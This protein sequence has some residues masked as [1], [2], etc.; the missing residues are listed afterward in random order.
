MSPELVNHFAYCNIPQ[1]NGVIPTAGGQKGPSGGKLHVRHTIVM[2]NKLLSCCLNR[3]KK[4]VK[5]LL[6]C[7]P[8]KS[9]CAVC[10]CTTLPHKPLPHHW[11]FIHWNAG[12]SAEKCQKD[13]KNTHSKVSGSVDKDMF[14]PRTGGKQRRIWGETTVPDHA[15]MVVK[16]DRLLHN[17][18]Q[19]PHSDRLVGRAG[20]NGRAVRWKRSTP[21]ATGVPNQCSHL[22]IPIQVQLGKGSNI[23]PTHAR[24]CAWKMSTR[25]A[26]K[27]Q[28]EY[29]N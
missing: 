28:T 6:A 14:I 17:R 16:T 11:K 7:T 25:S 5:T 21:H 22:D 18:L 3:I 13:D 2:T 1:S 8:A 12:L 29:L 27:A 15:H 19:C 26:K 24:A 10:S 23:L 20:G 9:M 4:Y